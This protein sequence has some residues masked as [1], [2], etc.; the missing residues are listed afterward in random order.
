MEL[1]HGLLARTTTGTGGV[2]AVAGDPHRPF[3]ENNGILNI[4]GNHAM[5]VREKFEEDRLSCS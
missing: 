1:H 4:I 2:N 3:A 5:T